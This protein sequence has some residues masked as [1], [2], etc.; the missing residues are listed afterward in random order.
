MAL[1]LVDHLHGCTPLKPCKS[2]EAAHFLKS[3]LSAPDFERLL[4][5]AGARGTIVVSDDDPI[6]V[7]DL[8]SRA[9]S[10]IKNDNIRTVKELTEKTR[11]ELLRMPNFGRVSLARIE[12]A[13]A[14][15]GRRLKDVS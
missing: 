14:V 10:A 9:F 6:D 11:R 12:T 13:L 4:S 5:I 3:K 8:D 15:C 7:L 1:F 2:C